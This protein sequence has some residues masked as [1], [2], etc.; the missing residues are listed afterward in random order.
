M[1]R[2]DL[3]QLLQNPD[4]AAQ[5]DVQAAGSWLQETTTDFPTVADTKEE[6]TLALMLPKLS[7]HENVTALHLAVAYRHID[8]VKMLVDEGCSLTAQTT[9]GWTPM[10]FA[11]AKSLRDRRRSKKK[12]GRRFSTTTTTT[13]TTTTGGGAMDGTAT[14]SAAE[15]EDAL[16]METD[17]ELFTYFLGLDPRMVHR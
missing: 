5:K 1:D 2:H 13:T 3:D 7:E 17:V 11:C 4:A 15:T 12:K 6:G 9:L 16:L 8:C 10:F 14:L